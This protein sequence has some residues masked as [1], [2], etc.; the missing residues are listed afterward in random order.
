MRANAR[1]LPYRRSFLLA[2]AAAILVGHAAHAQD[3]NDQR[4]CTGEW[5]ATDQERIASCTT[6]IGSG[7]Y[8][9]SNLA[10]LHNNRGVALRAQGNRSGALAD[11][12]RAIDLDPN[13][14]RAFANRA[15][16]L[17][18]ERDFDGAI[19]DLNRAIALNPADAASFMARGNAY[20]EKGDAARAIADYNEA[21]RLSPNYAAA[22]FNRALAR[23]RTGAVDL[24]IADYG[25]AIRFDSKNAAAYN[26]R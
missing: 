9:G 23:R 17:S 2:L 15:S 5:R 16:A 22:Y 21:I 13:S 3:L 14:P 25:Q 12:A 24:A 18:A 11:F 20:D 10:V 7:R 19:A 1:P 4:R 6:L 8:Q 26:N